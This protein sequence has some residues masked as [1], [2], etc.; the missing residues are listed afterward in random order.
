MHA[1]MKHTLANLQDLVPTLLRI[2]RPWVP[3]G[4]V[5]VD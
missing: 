1:Q 3:V 5:S 4:S 2:K